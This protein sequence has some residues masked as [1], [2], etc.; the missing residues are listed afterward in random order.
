MRAFGNGSFLI[1]LRFYR[2]RHGSVVRTQM[3]VFETGEGL[4]RRLIDYW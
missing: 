4:I 1:E 3:T 2:R